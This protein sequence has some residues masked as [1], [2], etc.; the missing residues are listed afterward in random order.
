MPPNVGRRAG[1]AAAFGAVRAYRGHEIEYSGC[2][3]LFVVI[4][5]AAFVSVQSRSAMALVLVL[6][7]LATAAIVAR[8]FVVPL[9]KE[10]RARHAIA[11][12]GATVL[13]RGSLAQ[14]HG[15]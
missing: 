15:S 2:G 4:L 13:S 10:W 3:T 14:F 8:V 7:I 9:R 1:R 12:E 5:A 11:L 6:C